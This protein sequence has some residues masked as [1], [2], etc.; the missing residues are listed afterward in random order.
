MVLA[1]SL[2]TRG[3]APA[4]V[5]SSARRLQFGGHGGRGGV[6]TRARGGQA[7]LETVLAVFFIT[8]MFLFVFQIAHMVTTKILLDHAAARAAR[9]R[10]VGFNEWMCLKSARV[11]MIPVAG[12]RTWPKEGERDEAFLVPDYMAAD[13]EGMSNGILDYERWHTMDFGIRSGLGNEVESHLAL[14]IPRFYS[15]GDEDSDTIEIEGE[16]RVESHF[17]LYMNDQGL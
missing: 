3:L 4:L 7:M 17:P 2:P 6:H 15:R 16:A 1:G 11:A 12:S 10:A 14:D 5:R 8:L 9:A 13:N